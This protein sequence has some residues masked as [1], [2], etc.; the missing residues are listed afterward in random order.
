M[1][2]PSLVKSQVF[3]ELNDIA[4]SIDS[5]GIATYV[6]ATKKEQDGDLHKSIQKQFSV[7]EQNDKFF[8]NKSWFAQK[9]T[10]PRIQL[11]SATLAYAA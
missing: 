3:N 1:F 2:A 5:K 4:D 9:D 10:E 11:R 8:M 7:T 6:T